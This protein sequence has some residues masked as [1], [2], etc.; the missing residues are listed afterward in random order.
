L[1]SLQISSALN[2]KSA[3]SIEVVELGGSLKGHHLKKKP[4]FEVESDHPG[5][6]DSA[7]DDSDGGKTTLPIGATV[8]CS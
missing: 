4:K 8:R 1:R 7:S 5:M 2:A 3:G 6:T